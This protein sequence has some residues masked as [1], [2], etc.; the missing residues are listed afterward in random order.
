MTTLA[1]VAASMVGA[2]VATYAAGGSETSVPHAFYIPVVVAALRFGPGGTVA[3]ACA[4]G[5]AA[6]PLMPLDVSEGASQSTVNWLAR[7]GF[8]VLV[9]QVANLLGR[10]SLPT[11]HEDR[12]HRRMCRDLVADARAGALRL[13]YQPVVDLRTR[14]I[15]GAEAL[16]RWDHPEHGRGGP[17]VFVAAAERVGCV[18]V[19]TRWAIVEGCRQ[20]AAWRDDVLAGVECFDLSV[21]ISA[22]DLGDPDLPGHV[23]RALEATDV[24]AS[25]LVLEVTE[26]ALVD[27][28]E[29]AVDGIVA[30]NALGVR[31][32]IDDFGAGH[33][34]LAQLGRLPAHVLKLDRSFIRAIEQQAS[35]AVLVQGIVA[36][37]N[38][39]DVTTVAEGIETLEQAEIVRATGCDRAQGYLF[40]R[41]LGPDRFAHVLE[42]V[43]T[44]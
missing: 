20:L 5:V 10:H 15:V 1:F 2:W 29:R 14:A 24:P 37:A 32:A 31:L 6:G 34:S 8:L 22:A 4:A 13:V 18:H 21:N 28:V 11:L 35:G 41:P 30:L 33:S 42:T 12:V 27:D 9:G 7:L 40:A 23:R 3:V 17:A 25:W 38:A 36:L 16:M 19:L 44:R 43:A 39:M 26:T